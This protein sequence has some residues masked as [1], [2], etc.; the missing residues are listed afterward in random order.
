MIQVGTEV[1]AEKGFSSVGIEEILQ[2]ASAPKG[3][4]YYY[5]ASKQEFGLAV[6][7]HY[8]QI[9]EQ[10]LYRILGDEHTA[11]LERIRNYI[12]EGMHGMEKYSYRRGCL[13]GNIGQEL[14][15]LN[16]PFRSR[17]EQV[18]ANWTRHIKVCLDA[19]IA[20]GEI[21]EGLD[22]GQVARYFWG[23]W[24]GAILQCKL[25]RSVR[26]LQDFAD[27]LFHIVLR[28]RQQNVQ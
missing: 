12:E 2:R 10:R 22:T 24:E 19:A 3:S 23:A 16:E 13:I 21:D 1:L 8:D 9:W 6:I 28:K 7:A 17:I 26:P 4:F 27:L 14:G 25:V 18:F 20:Q 15:G 11:P 5:F